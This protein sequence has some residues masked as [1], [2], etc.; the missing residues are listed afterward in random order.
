[1]RALLAASLIAVSVL[2]P[3]IARAGAPAAPAGAERV[4]IRGEGGWKLDAFYVPPPVKPAA[5]KDKA[6]AVILTHMLNRTKEDWTPLVGKLSA[7]GFAVVAY[8][9]RG[10]GKSV[11]AS[12][13]PGSWKTFK[14]ADWLAAEKDVGR[15]RDWL[16][17]G[18][19]AAVDPGRVALCGGSIGANLSLRAL[20]RF[21]ELRG[22]VLLSPG[23]DFKGVKTAE[24]AGKL[25]AGRKIALFAAAGDYKGYC[26][27]TAEELAKAAG[28]S[29]IVKKVYPGSEHGTKMFGAVAGVEVEI[30]KA[31][32]TMTAPAATAPKNDVKGALDRVL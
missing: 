15:V 7:A 14:A 12:G 30:V 22:A 31:L 26:A 21:P 8:D 10:H 1:M 18:K 29:S 19:A 11:D 4:T 3:P 23:L 13:E 2:A 17:A 16:L 20:V 6:P 28:D 32:Q 24:A 25:P 27:K 9:M 5:G